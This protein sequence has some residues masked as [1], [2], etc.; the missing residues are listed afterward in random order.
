MPRSAEISLSATSASSRA[1]SESIIRIV[2]KGPCLRA[3]RTRAHDLASR[4]SGWSRLRCRPGCPWVRGIS[5]ARA[6]GVPPRRPR[7]RTVPNGS[8]STTTRSMSESASASPRHREPK[9]ITC[10]GSATSTMVAVICRKSASSTRTMLAFSHAGGSPSPEISDQERGVRLALADNP[11]TPFHGIRMETPPIEVKNSA[12]PY[13]LETDKQ[14][15]AFPAFA[16]R[17]PALGRH[18]NGSITDRCGTGQIHPRL[19]RQALS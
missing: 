15:S 11:G 5:Q 6:K 13:F 16:V 3:V 2:H 19:H 9:R 10:S 17:G 12:R 4:A 14:G 7:S 18:G 1:C 8:V